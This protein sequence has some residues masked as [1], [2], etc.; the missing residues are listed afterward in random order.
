MAI[1]PHYRTQFRNS[2]LCGLIRMARAFKLP[3]RCPVS[4]FAI[5][6]KAARRFAALQRR[7]PGYKDAAG[8][9]TSNKYLGYYPE[10]GHVGSG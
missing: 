5:D 4:E 1:R 7:A 8:E 2:L 6:I 9:K 3:V 10:S